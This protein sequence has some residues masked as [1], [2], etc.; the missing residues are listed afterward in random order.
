MVEALKAGGFALG[1]NVK[2]EWVDSGKI[3]PE[4]E[5]SVFENV[6]GII[7]PGGFGGR[8]TEGMIETC[9]YA[10]ENGVPC[11]GICLGYRVFA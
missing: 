2:I 1:V 6:D 11:L 3:T 5:K 4:T 10:R 9:R 8:A 7:I